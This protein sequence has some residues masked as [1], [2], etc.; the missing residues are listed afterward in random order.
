MNKKAEETQN[1]PKPDK[2]DE[3]VDLSRMTLAE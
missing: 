1:A 3:P 2:K